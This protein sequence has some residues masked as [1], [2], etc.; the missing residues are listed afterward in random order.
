[1]L[2]FYEAYTDY[3]YQMKQFEDMISQVAEKVTGS[4]KVMYQEKEINFAPPWRRLSVMDGVK[5]YAGFNPDDLSDQ[6]L[7]DKIKSFGS[8][9][10]KPGLRGEMIM[11]AFELK[12]EP[13]IFQPTFIIDLSLIHI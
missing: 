3:N 4:M 8:E 9:M 1:M 13:E 2:E 11:E 12:A 7:F 5:E 6:E 10:K